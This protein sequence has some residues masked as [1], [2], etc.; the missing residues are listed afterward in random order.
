MALRGVTP[1][2]AETEIDAA[3]GRHLLAFLSGG[4]R[5][6]RVFW[7]GLGEMRPELAG[8]SVVIVTPDPT[9][10]PRRGIARLAPPGVPVVMSTAAWF[11]YGA[12]A[13]PWFALVVDGTVTASGNAPTWAALAEL[14]R[15]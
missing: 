10:E 2:G 12:G 1:D 6:C 8:T 7:R 15:G 9:T 14:V 5:P 4:C 3:S 11:A 13:A